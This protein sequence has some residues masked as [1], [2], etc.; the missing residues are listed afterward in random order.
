MDNFTGVRKEGRGYYVAWIN[1]EISGSAS[2]PA[3][4]QA[5]FEKEVARAQMNAQRAAS[6]AA[7]EARRA[8][9]AEVEYSS[10]ER[11]GMATA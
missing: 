6:N 10:C 5:K 11:L 1:G 8:E 3:A 4:A 2:N 9:C 7:W